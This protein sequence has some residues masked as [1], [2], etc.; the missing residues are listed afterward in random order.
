MG[1][2]MLS[3]LDGTH[4]RNIALVEPRRD[5]RL[6]PLRPAAGHTTQ[7]SHIGT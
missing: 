6:L 4:E 1:A 2:L 5:E 7:H 3:R